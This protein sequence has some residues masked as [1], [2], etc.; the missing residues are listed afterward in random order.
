MDGRDS[1]DGVSGWSGPAVVGARGAPVWRALALGVLLVGLLALPGQAQGGSPGEP[2]WRDLAR[3]RAE[4]D[5]AR[6]RLAGAEQDL[7]AT[8]AEL[9][10]L[11]HRQ[12]DT[13]GTDAELATRF[14]EQR[15]S[16]R[17]LAIEAFMAGS[18]ITDTAALLDTA[19]AGDLTFR[20]ELLEVRSRNLVAESDLMIE[21]R[22]DVS[23]LGLA[24]A[25]EQDEVVRRI[26]ALRAEVTAATTLVADAE[27]VVEIAEIHAEAD[28]EMSR[29]GRTEPSPEQ[30]ARL[31]WCE[32]HDDYA[33]D[34]GNGYYGAYQFDLVT[35]RGTGG[36][37]NPA[38][39][40][41]EEQDARARLLYSWRGW[42]PWPI[43]GQ[44]LPRH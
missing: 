5:T 16:A 28:A 32:S 8:E 26:E 35:W 15:A 42:A 36:F 37:G 23:E 40:S 21:L 24:L 34:T 25:A 1:T 2:P 6:L 44:Y 11:Q 18:A 38:H 22:E 17:R 33:I 13:H 14:E 19:E 20:M 30:W 43:C 12:A 41:P 7:A 39:M 29:R 3:A 27:W 4:L 10:E 9:V 31:R